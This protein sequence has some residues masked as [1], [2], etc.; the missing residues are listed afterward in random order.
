MM[1]F[2]ATAAQGFGDLLASELATLGAIEI[3][4]NGAR[5]SFK[6]DH[7]TLYRVLL[8]SRLASRILL[9]ITRVA[10]NDGDTLY[11]EIRAIHWERYFRP[12][13]T[14]AVDASAGRDA[15]IHH[16]HYAALR[17][18]DAIAD[19]FAD[20]F[21]S[22]PDVVT[23]R[24]DL[25]IHIEL[26]GSNAHLGLDLS[27]ES[28]HRRGYRR[29]A[30]AAPIKESLA[31]AMLLLA[32]WPQRA[33]AGSALLDPFCG[34][35]TLLI[36]AA[37][38]AAE[39]AP[40]ITRDYFGLSGWKRHDE[41]LW[42]SIR[43]AAIAERAAAIS[44]LPPIIGYDSDPTAIAAARTNIAAAGLGDAIT[45]ACH[46]FGARDWP[47]PSST[48]GLLIT[49]P[50]YG[51]RLGD[52]ASLLPLYRLL[53]ERLAQMGGWQLALFSTNPTLGAAIGRPPFQRVA[54]KNG[55][56]EGELLRFAA[57][58][59]ATLAAQKS[60]STMFGNRLQKNLRQLERWRKQESI[61]AFRAY[62]ADMPEYAVA[63][64]CYDC[65]DGR[66][67]HVQEYQA[68]AS[69]DPLKAQ[70]RL[71]SAV[72]AL[73]AIF[74]LTRDRIILKRRERQR[75]KAQYQRHAS[76]GAFHIVHEGGC[77]LWVNFHDYLDTGLFLDHRPLRRHLGKIAAGR[78]LLNLF[79]YTGSATI[80][81]AVGGA[82]STTSV[83]LSATYLDWLESNLELN[84]L[85]DDRH[86]TLQADIL[87]WLEEADRAGAHYDIIFLD[88]PTFSN[89]KRMSTTLDIQRDH[90]TLIRAAAALLA[91][92]GELYFSNN[93]RRFKL[94]TAALADLQCDDITRQTLDADFQRTPAPHH[95]WR[96][97][98]RD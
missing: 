23:D 86:T 88:P 49:N 16:S 98:R 91:P 65:E 83:D 28:L 51:A 53:G 24:P 84:G 2:T 33:S 96:I 76:E 44:R 90:V 8:G 67:L 80:H 69:I 95:C 27:G 55:P 85:A 25:R 22:R 82:A 81:A 31:A 30:G 42:Q 48:N 61:S 94:D 89:S 34:S 56:L 43:L 9:P 77:R 6:G 60:G 57:P 79:C 32:E 38:M 14:F 17:V 26:H 74:G 58:D 20:R 47:L 62:D 73:P 92:Q 64:D 45:L 19:Y 15:A 68:P 39:I 37:L 97:T 10:A 93:Y 4:N 52:E 36:E 63:I 75:G 78:H 72:D 35:G 21:G 29:E 41:N 18:K 5:L 1:K 3:R 54:L 59:S 7:A 70:Q 46:D 50:P 12:H 87:P 71:E 11:R 66:W 40:G 13:A